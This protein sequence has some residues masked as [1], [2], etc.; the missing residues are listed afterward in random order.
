M[1]HIQFINEQIKV[2]SGSKVRKKG[3][4]LFRTLNNQIMKLQNVHVV[5]TFTKNIISLAKLMEEGDIEIEWNRF[6]IKMMNQ[7]ARRSV[8]SRI[9][10]R[11]SCVCTGETGRSSY[12]SETSKVNGCK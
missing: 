8:L 7:E 9:T 11:T 5:P 12:E 4:V 6:S 10:V 3:T 2:G 1:F